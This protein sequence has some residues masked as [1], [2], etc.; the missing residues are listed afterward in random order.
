[1]N[2]QSAS[3]SRLVQVA[4]WLR[5]FELLHDTFDIGA[6]FEFRLRCLGIH[7]SGRESAIHYLGAVGVVLES[8]A[9]TVA[10]WDTLSHNR[11]IMSLG[12]TH[13]GN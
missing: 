1:M 9:R 2:C 11:T 6:G 10:N 7:F 3:L 5:F 4:F 12:D 13:R 8:L